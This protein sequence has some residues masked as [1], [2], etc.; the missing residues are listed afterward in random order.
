MSYSQ[1]L[2]DWVTEYEQQ[3]G[4]KPSEKVLRVAEHIGNVGEKLIELGRKDRLNGEIAYSTTVF[5]ELVKQR[6]AIADSDR[7]DE[8]VNG[9]ATLWQSDYMDGYNEGKEG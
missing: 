2:T 5:R 8:L 1:I 6:F 9:I 7:E 3:H 4:R